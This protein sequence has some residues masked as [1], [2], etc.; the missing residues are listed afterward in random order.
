[1]QARLRES[2]PS[3]EPEIRIVRT[4]GDRS[5][6]IPLASGTTVGIFV[7][8]IEEEL[9]SGRIDLAVH[10]LKDLPTSQPPGLEVAAI[11]VR[12][13]PR[14]VLVLREGRDL[15]DLP[16]GA[17]IGTGSP[18]RIGQIK[19]LRNDLKFEPIRG[20]VDTRIR[21][22][23][24]GR[25]DALVLAAAGLNRLEIR[26]VPW[27]PFSL[28]ELLPAPGQGALGIEIR[29]GDRTLGE[30]LRRILDHPPSAASA[31]AERSFLMAL[32]GG[33]QMPVGALGT[34]QGSELILRGA[35]AAPDGTAVL[36]DEER[37]AASAPELLGALLGERMLRSGAAELM[38]RGAPG[39][40]R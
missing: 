1:V 20:N 36:R 24:E 22:L 35:V 12:E 32:G 21:K 31:R 2:D 3:A 18:R 29:S 39:A 13:D 40:G 28:E 15:R 14:D 9:L 6:S 23:R 10:S 26:D 7:R 16:P 33:C 11:P 30:L 19:A 25:V 17:V 8:E 34:P 38:A 37:G 27:H 4:E 5:Q